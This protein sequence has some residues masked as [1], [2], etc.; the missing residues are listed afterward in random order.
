ML[1]YQAGDYT[2]DITTHMS[3]HPQLEVMQDTLPLPYL[4]RTFGEMPNLEKKALKLCQGT[5][6]DIGC[7]AGSH[8]LYLQR[9]GMSVTALDSSKGAI[10]TCKARG[11]VNCVQSD[12]MNFTGHRFDTLL[13]VM[14][15]LGI[16]GT[17]KKLESLLHH[18][19]TLLHPKGQILLD[20]SDI[21]YLF[22]S[23]E[24]GGHWIPAQES[25]YGEVRFQMEYRG[26]MSTT[27]EWLYLDFNTLQTV[28]HAYNF[29]CELVSEGNHYDYLARIT[30]K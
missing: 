13:L 7:G 2:A 20:S 9:K 5:V 18:L 3:I 30:S 10:E 11:I 14:N 15:G 4:F 17:I 28:A 12:I 25:Y 22:H 1:D 24:D 26:K 8:S 23:D 16:A 27:F 19:R 29:N 21:I 6:L